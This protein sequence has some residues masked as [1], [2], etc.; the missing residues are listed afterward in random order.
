MNA[1]EGP[2]SES[3]VLENV[4]TTFAQPGEG[5]VARHLW[6][7]V[8]AVVA[9]V[10]V[11]LMITAVGVAL[12]R[13]VKAPS[14]EVHTALDEQG[15]IVLVVVP[16]PDP[17]EKV[18]DDMITRTATVLRERIDTLGVKQA[19]VVTRGS[20]EATTITLTLVG[21][22]ATQSVRALTRQGALDFRPVVLADAGTSPTPTA[23]TLPPPLQ[24]ES[25]S[26][27]LRS[28]FAAADCASPRSRQ[29]AVAQDPA[30]WLIACT[31]RGD[32]KY[33][34]E[35]ATMDGSNIETVRVVTP[36]GS[37][38][39]VI[40]VVFDPRGTQALAETSSRLATKKSPAN[41]VA[42]V[43]DSVVMSS[44]WFSE[45][46]LGGSVLINGS[47]TNAEA[48]EFADLLDHG[49]LPFRLKVTEVRTVPAR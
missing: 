37:D 11:L 35:P 43:L 40:E 5:K 6:A 48:R 20:G 42:I 4:E 31:A 16:F 12:W 22:V 21:R 28:N 41:E 46:I 26:A 3:P 23:P 18:T 36:S 29:P 19:E 9:V 44:P 15:G 17:G 1:V 33:L 13:N 39:Q 45:P 24:S 14:S 30:R 7:R 2:D 34:L 38:N 32:I 8:L 10:L 47:F 25:D 49:A 27:A